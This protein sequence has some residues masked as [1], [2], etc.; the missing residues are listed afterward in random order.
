MVWASG[1]ALSEAGSAPP[2]SPAVEPEEH[3]PI[4]N[5]M[6]MIATSAKMIQM[7]AEERLLGALVWAEF[8]GAL[9][10]GRSVRVE[11]AR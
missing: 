11:V 4:A 2:S 6:A 1:A 5:A 3:D 9:L 7:V 8:A 10:R